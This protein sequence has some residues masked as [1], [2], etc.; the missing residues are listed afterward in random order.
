MDELYVFLGMMTVT[1]GIIGILAI[2][3]GVKEWLLK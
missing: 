2:Y 3:Y 1:A